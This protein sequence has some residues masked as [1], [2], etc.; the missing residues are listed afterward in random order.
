MAQIRDL[1]SP[2]ATVQ[3]SSHWYQ[4]PLRYPAARSMDIIDLDENTIDAEVF[5]SLPLKWDDVGGLEK[6]KLELQEPTTMSIPTILAEAIA[7][8]CN[9][10]FISV[11]WLGESE[12]N[13][14]DVL[15]NAHCVAI[16]KNV[17]LV[18]ATNRPNQT[19]STLLRPRRLDDLHIYLWMG[20][21][22][23]DRPQVSLDFLPNRTH[24]DCQQAVKLT[25]IELDIHQAL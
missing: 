9:A 25:T 4:A 12:A 24:G 11:K 23:H 3:V 10:N 16:L 17:F 14:R 18:G 21:E 22:P 8:E 5:D 19:D 20:A 7:N 6:V 1:P 15:D 13:V 2:P